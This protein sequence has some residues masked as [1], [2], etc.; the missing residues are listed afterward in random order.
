[1]FHL[2]F[3]NLVHGYVNP[4]DHDREQS[5]IFLHAQPVYEDLSFLLL[6]S[7]TFRSSDQAR[8]ELWNPDRDSSELVHLE[9]SMRLV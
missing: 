5:L 6:P 2:V 7:L 9:L 4:A 8:K 1:M 3:K